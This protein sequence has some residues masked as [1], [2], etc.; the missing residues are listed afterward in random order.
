MVD[1]S[2]VQIQ[3]S[4]RRNWQVGDIATLIDNVGGA[5]MYSTIDRLKVTFD[6]NISYYSTARIRFFFKYF[7]V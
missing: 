6:F 4:L 7:I 1:E 5:A 3:R 2:I